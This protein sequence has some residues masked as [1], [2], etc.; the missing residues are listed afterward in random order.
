MSSTKQ[1]FNIL[2]VKE[3]AKKLKELTDYMNSNVLSY[4]RDFGTFH[5]SRKFNQVHLISN[6]NSPTPALPSFSVQ[7][8]GRG[9]FQGWHSKVLSR[10][11]AH[12]QFEYYENGTPESWYVATLKSN[13]YGGL[14]LDYHKLV[15]DEQLEDEGFLFQ[16][17]LVLDDKDLFGVFCASWLRHFGANNV[18]ITCNLDVDELN[19]VHRAVFIYITNS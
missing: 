7:E 8:V 2:E 13:E 11:N 1:N 6:I 5:F 3:Y 10:P 19:E 14:G 4:S 15:S 16:Q 12:Y 18:F 9:A 17:A